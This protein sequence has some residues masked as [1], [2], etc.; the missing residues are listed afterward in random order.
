MNKESKIV[1]R[2]Q[3][4]KIMTLNKIGFQMKSNAMAAYTYTH[5]CVVYHEDEM[6]S[7]HEIFGIRMS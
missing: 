3:D 1:S 4:I 2:E 6:K 7:T 5:V